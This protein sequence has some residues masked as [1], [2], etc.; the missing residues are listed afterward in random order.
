MW[1]RRSNRH[2]RQLG[3]TLLELMFAVAGS[4]IVVGTA[5]AVYTIGLKSY[6]NDSGRNQANNTALQ[7]AEYISRDL[8]NASQIE[9][10][11]GGYTTGSSTIIITAP[12]YNSGGTITGSYDYIIYRISSGNLVR[13]VL[14]ASGSSRTAEANRIIVRK[15][16]SL[17]FVYKAH[18]TFEGDGNRNSFQLTT[19][20]SGTPVCR[21]NGDVILSGYSLSSSS[22]TATFSAIPAAGS[23]I[24]F[25]YTVQPGMS[26]AISAVAEVQFTVDA[27]TDSCLDGSA[28]TVAVARLRNK[29]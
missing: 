18:D 13:T 7:A 21:F 29:K 5:L 19:Y 12:A 11:Y 1:T 17:Q 9:N 4:A 10:T 15:V 24:E 22:H 25:V 20:W 27:G 2:N 8:R 23:V 26:Q 3:T 28:Q 14:P 16:S 6:Q